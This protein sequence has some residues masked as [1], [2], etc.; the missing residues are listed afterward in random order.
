[1]DPNPRLRQ[2]EAGWSLLLRGQ[3]EHGGRGGVEAVQSQRGCLRPTISIQ[4]QPEAG[5]SLLIE[6][7]KSGGH[8]GRVEVFRG[9][10]RLL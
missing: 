8:G 9:Q 2:P 1:M 4:R 7:K 10:E 6:A 5:W 3:E